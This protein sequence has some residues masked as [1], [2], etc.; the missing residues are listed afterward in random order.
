[1]IAKMQEF[2]D[3]EPQAFFFLTQ[4]VAL[5]TKFS[6]SCHCVLGPST[7][8]RYDRSERQALN[9]DE[10]AAPKNIHVIVGYICLKQTR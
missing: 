6:S 8:R 7:E 3:P 2:R 4:L 5:I 1:M 10:A 9:R